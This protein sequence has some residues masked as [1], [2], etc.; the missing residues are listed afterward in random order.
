MRHGAWPLQ[1][2]L[3]DRLKRFN[4][5]VA[6]RRFGKTVFGINELLRHAA[7]KR[8]KA[9]RYA[10]LAPFQR[11]AKAVGPYPAIVRAERR[12]FTTETQRTQRR[13]RV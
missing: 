9:A 10:Y 8:K 4:V 11:Q 12:R 1:Q 6:H 2:E 7:E 3:H 5:I 13:K